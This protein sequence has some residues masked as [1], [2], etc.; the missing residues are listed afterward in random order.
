MFTSW[1]EQST[2]AELSIASVFTFPPP[3]AYAIRARWVSPRFP[4][5]PMTRQRSSPASMR[6]ASFVLS[7]TSECVSDAARTYV[8]MPPFQSR[9]AGAR[10]IARIS[11]FGVSSSASVPSAARTGSVSA[12]DF[13][14]RGWTP[15]PAE[16]TV[17]S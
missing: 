17:S 9:S 13:A 16:M 10:R 4:P 11:S 6:T 5:S 7:P 3:S 14:L 8:P 12:I 2:P 15:P 1:S